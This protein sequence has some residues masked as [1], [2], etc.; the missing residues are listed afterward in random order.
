[1]EVHVLRNAKQIM[2][3]IHSFENVG[4]ARLY[5]FQHLLKFLSVEVIAVKIHGRAINC[6][7]I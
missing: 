2:E 5:H 7:T 3:L 4:R 6:S 1:M